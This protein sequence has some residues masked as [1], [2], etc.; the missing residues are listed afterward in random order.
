[1]ALTFSPTNTTLS[2]PQQ[3]PQGTVY[4]ILTVFEKTFEL[5]E[6]SIPGSKTAEK[7]KAEDVAAI[8][9]P[10]VKINEYI[11]SRNELLS[12]RIDSTEFLPTITVSVAMSNQLFIAK[13]MPKDGDIISIAIR[14]G[15]DI[16]KI[17]RNDYVITG[18]HSVVNYTETKSPVILTFYGELFIPSLRSH[19]NDFAFVGT[20]FEVLQYFAKL[21]ELGFAS[22]EHNTNDKQLWLKANTEGS[23][24]VNN[25]VERAWGDPKSF[26][27]CW[28]DV[29]YNLN[30]VNINKQLL[31]AESEIDIAPLLTNVDKNFNY[32]VDTS[33]INTNATVKVFTNFPHFKTT[34]FFINTWRPINVSSTITFQVGARM[35]AE[36]FEHNS[37]L[38]NNP[39]STKYWKVPIDPTYDPNKTNKSILLR[40]RAAY[41][42]DPANTELKRANYNYVELYRKYPWLGIQYTISNPDDDNLQWDGNHHKNYQVAKVQNLI[43]NKELDKLNLKIEVNGN[44]FS[45]IRGDKVPIAL[46]RTDPVENYRINPDTNFNDALDLFYSGWYLVKG[47]T[48]SWEG[49]NEQM[50]KSNFTHEFVLT[51]REWP[52]PIPV[53]PIATNTNNI[54]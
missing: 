17:V 24:F 15:S 30:F 16:L 1:M 26:Y 39:Q 44:N 54:P 7:Q 31:S 20:S 34:P 10:L 48:L 40:G 11:F 2:K 8:E 9:Y 33:E 21:F 19:G 41:V 42:D 12:V 13:E 51:R 46:I 23:M 3:E 5:D 52:P 25:V 45:I 14:N 47:F 35:T 29:Y 50:I 18:V 53:E 4:R 43:N 37:N 28:V 27:R 22:N 38:Y 32:G 36:L 49:S 6:L